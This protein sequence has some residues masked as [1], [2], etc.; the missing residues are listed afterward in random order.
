MS[1][2]LLAEIIRKDFNSDNILVK[3]YACGEMSLELLLES[4]HYSN[5]IKERI[6]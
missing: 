4:I 3:Y 6:M 2:K 1:N 5:I